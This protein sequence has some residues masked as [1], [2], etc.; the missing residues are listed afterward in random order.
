MQLLVFVCFPFKGMA[1]LKNP[2]A[3]EIAELSFYKDQ[4]FSHLHG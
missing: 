3:L 1:A 4:G 2:S